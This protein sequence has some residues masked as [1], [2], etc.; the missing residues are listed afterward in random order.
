MVIEEWF[1]T[2]H[3]RDV[4]ENVDERVGIGWWHSGQSRVFIEWD[5]DQ[6]GVSVGG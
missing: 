3:N 6:V 5:K 4:L 2:N 1:Y